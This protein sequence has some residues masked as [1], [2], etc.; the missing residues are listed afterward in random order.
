M[1]IERGRVRVDVSVRMRHRDA[2]PHRLRVRTNGGP[3]AAFEWAVELNIN[4]L[5]EKSCGVQSLGPD[6]HE[7]EV[8]WDGAIIFSQSISEAGVDRT[9]EASCRVC[10]G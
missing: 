3:H 7:V 6:S 10:P 8:Q 4:A 1:S 2:S 9:I 5:N